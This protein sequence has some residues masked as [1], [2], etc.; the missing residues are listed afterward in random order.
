MGSILI[1]SSMK[2]VPKGPFYNIPV[3]DQIM[4]WRRPSDKPLSEPMMVRLSTHICV[5]RPQWVNDVIW[6]HRFRSTLFCKELL[7]DG[8]KPLP[9]PMLTYHQW[10]HVVFTWEQFH[11]KWSSNQSLEHVAKYALAFATIL[12]RDTESKYSLNKVWQRYNNN[13]AC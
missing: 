6:W 1:K 7:P 4:A 2:F 11:W 13:C 10:S 8:T 9:E 12:M 5:T 3:L